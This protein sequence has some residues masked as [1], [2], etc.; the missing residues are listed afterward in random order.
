MR[1]LPRRVSLGL[2][3]A[4][5]LGIAS[6]AP[7]LAQSVVRGEVKDEWGNA[8]AKASVL[9]EPESSG[10]SQTT[11][12]DD[13][14]RFQFVGLASG[15]WAFTVTADGYQGVRVRA[16]V[17]QGQNRPMTVDLPVVPSGSRFR[18]TTRF[19]AEP[20]GQPT[21]TFEE[22][23]TF[24]FEDAQGEGEGTYGI[25]ELTAELV[26]REYDGPPN[27]FSIAT[28][29]VVEFSDKMFTSLVMD[30]QKLVKKS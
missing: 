19:V 24:R 3:L 16:N 13:D 29:I 4:A 11:T 2:S 9:A 26:I 10:G 6:A 21:I 8:I 20:G 15:P 5:A 22:N 30:G 23:G 12:A 18:S 28:P 17:Q 7:A 27:K 1:P 14:G 25:N